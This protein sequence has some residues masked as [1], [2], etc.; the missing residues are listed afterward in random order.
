MLDDS[1]EPGRLRSTDEEDAFG[2]EEEEESEMDY[3]YIPP[4]YHQ[5]RTLFQKWGNYLRLW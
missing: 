3:E 4:N 2:R 1:S 5:N